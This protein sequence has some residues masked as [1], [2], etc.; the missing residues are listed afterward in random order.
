MY[1]IWAR[2]Q[3]GCYDESVTMQQIDAPDRLT[4]YWWWHWHF[5]PL[6]KC[7][8][9]YV[10]VFQFIQQCLNN[11]LTDLHKTNPCLICVPP[12]FT[13]VSLFAHLITFTIFPHIP[14]IVTNFV[15]S[16]APIILNPIILNTKK[17]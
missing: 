2:Q 10:C 6:S 15:P 8:C 1:C 12:T 11:T 14:H 13:F 3:H 4:G 16:F 7:V 5:D 9:V 17:R